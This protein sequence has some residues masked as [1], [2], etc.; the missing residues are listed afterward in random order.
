MNI[1]NYKDDSK[2]H[3][4]RVVNYDISIIEI[5]KTYLEPS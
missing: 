4:M 5:L 2:K 1:Q 3:R